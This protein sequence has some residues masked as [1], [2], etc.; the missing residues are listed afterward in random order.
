MGLAG[1]ETSTLFVQGWP[2]TDLSCLLD[3]ESVGNECEVWVDEAHELPNSL[4]D[5][6]AGVEEDLNPTAGITVRIRSEVLT[7]PFLSG[8]GCT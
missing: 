4:L 1:E 7:Q 6:V 2:L 5:A 8:G 3:V